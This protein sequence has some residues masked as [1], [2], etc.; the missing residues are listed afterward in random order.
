M[1][2][3]PFQRGEPAYGTEMHRV[4]VFGGHT[5][6]AYSGKTDRNVV[7]RVKSGA[8]GWCAGGPA[9]TIEH[10]GGAAS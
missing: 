5:M 8:Y 3:P 10:L 7:D 1:R 2:D 9:E 6:S 4:L